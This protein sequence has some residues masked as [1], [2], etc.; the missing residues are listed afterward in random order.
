MMASFYNEEQ[1]F[2]VGFNK[3]LG[4]HLVEA[5]NGHAIISMTIQPEYLNP[6]GLVHGGV[7]FALADSAGANAAVSYGCQVV[8]V[9][10]EIKYMRPAL[11]STKTLT[12]TAREIKHGRTISFY[13]V[14]ITTDDG[15][16][17][18]RVSLTYFNK[19][20]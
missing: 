17:V 20:K 7:I 9:N 16:E 19:D 4:M 18:A 6:A 8:T 11:G 12:G 2:D 13:E 3:L 10:S 15:T 14:S 1:Y 5:E